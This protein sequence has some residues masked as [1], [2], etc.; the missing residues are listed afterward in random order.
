VREASL[1]LLRHLPDEAWRRSGEFAGGRL[2]ALAAACFVIGHEIHHL[3][4]LRERY[5]NR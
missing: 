5:L 3:N 2:T 1:A 4:I